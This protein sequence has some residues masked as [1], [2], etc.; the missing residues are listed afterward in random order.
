M[1]VR[2]VREGGR[3]GGGDV[4]DRDEGLRDVQVEM[5]TTCCTPANFSAT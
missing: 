5:W 4:G 3:R 2:R 1:E